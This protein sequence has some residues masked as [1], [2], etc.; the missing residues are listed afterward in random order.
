MAPLLAMTSTNRSQP[1]PKWAL[2]TIRNEETTSSAAG[3]VWTSGFCP[4]VR[5][6]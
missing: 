3:T 6:E 1:L 2:A 5:A 4:Q